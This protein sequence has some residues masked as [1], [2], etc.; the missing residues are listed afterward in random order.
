MGDSFPWHPLSP[1]VI[2][3]KLKYYYKMRLSG[4]YKTLNT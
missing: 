1:R 2:F 3:K 4:S